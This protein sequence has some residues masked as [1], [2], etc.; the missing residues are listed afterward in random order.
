MAQEKIKV[1]HKIRDKVGEQEYG[2]LVAILQDEIKQLKEKLVELMDK[3][4][5]ARKQNKKDLIETLSEESK[6]VVKGNV[7][8]QIS[9][10]QYLEQSGLLN[11]SEQEFD[12]AMQKTF[13]KEY[14]EIKKEI[15]QSVN[16]RTAEYLNDTNVQKKKKEF[17]RRMNKNARKEAEEKGL[18]EEFTIKASEYVKISDKTAAFPHPDYPEFMVTISTKDVCGLVD[19]SKVKKNRSGQNV[20]DLSMSVYKDAALEF[21]VP[22]LDAVSGAPVKDKKGTPIFEKFKMTYGEFDKMVKETGVTAAIA[23]KRKQ[24][25]LEGIAQQ[26][27][28][29]AVVKQK[30]AVNAKK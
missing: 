12:E 27:K 14:S 7:S 9:Q 13:P 8:R 1:H 24:R 10:M 21:K 6:E 30:G 17:V 23:I 29:A 22:V 2:E 5:V 15:S 20:G 3:W 11:A 16:S 28:Q 19:D 25:E 26:K 4:N 18:T